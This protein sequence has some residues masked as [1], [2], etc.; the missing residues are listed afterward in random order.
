MRAWF[1]GLL[2]LLLLPLLFLLAYLGVAS[3]LMLW[4]ANRGVEQAQDSRAE[5]QAW[6]LSNGIHTDLVFPL[7]AHGVDWTELFPP[8]HL[9]A[10]PPPDAQYIAIG[11]GDREIYLYTPTWGDLTARRALTA[12]LGVNGALLHV[13]YLRRADL[14]SGAY[15]LP[16]SLAQYETLH[17]HVIESLPQGRAQPVPGAHYAANDAFYEAVGNTHFFDTCNNWTGRGLRRAGV[18]VSR[19]TP[20]DFNVTWHLQPARPTATAPSSR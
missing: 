17:R 15:S 8:T 18:T 11:R 5:V 4:P 19:W 16:L 3:A 9:R 10:A 12:A 13:S 20:F 2:I 7:R 1:R 6:V 14:A